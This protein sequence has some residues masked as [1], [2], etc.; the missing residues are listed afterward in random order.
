MVVLLLSVCGRCTL[1][2]HRSSK[3]CFSCSPRSPLHSDY[4]AQSLAPLDYQSQFSPAWQLFSL[5]ASLLTND[6]PNDHTAII[7]SVSVKALMCPVVEVFLSLGIRTSNSV[8]TRVYG[9]RKEAFLSGSLGAMA[10][11]LILC[12]LL[13]PRP[14]YCNCLGPNSL[15]SVFHHTPQRA[16]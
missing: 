10:G 9:D 2:R 1:I 5:S 7:T 12:R 16:E 15:M 13:D 4:A 8:E 14:M 6:A 11:G 3:E